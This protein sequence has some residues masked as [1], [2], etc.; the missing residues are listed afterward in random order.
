MY[1]FC[2]VALCE[3]QSAC[4]PDYLGQQYRAD[5]IISPISH[6]FQVSA[7]FFRC[8]VRI[9]VRYRYHS[10][11]VAELYLYTQRTSLKYSDLSPVEPQEVD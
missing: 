6:L 2:S 7:I 8:T 3:V 1:D 9:S 11:P 4:Q 10:A 5:T